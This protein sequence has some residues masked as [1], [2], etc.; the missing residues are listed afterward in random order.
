MIKETG[1]LSNASHQK[2][3]YTCLQILFKSAQQD[4]TA[5]RCH[6]NRNCLKQQ[7]RSQGRHGVLGITEVLRTPTYISKTNWYF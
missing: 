7:V 5:W 1:F 3:E 4:F 6:I 2:N